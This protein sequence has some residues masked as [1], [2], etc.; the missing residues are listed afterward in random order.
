MILL[1]M[2]LIVMLHRKSLFQLEMIL[3][4]ALELSSLSDRRDETNITCDFGSGRLSIRFEHS[5]NTKT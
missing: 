2:N 5:S 1:V 3:I 4:I